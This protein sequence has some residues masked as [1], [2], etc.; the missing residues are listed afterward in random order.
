MAD[1]SG[2]EIAGY[3]IERLIAR[4]GMG[5]V[6]LARQSFPERK[7]ALKLL[8]HELASDPAF[9]ERFVR[10][11]NAAASLEHP[12]IVPVH[13]AGESDG[14]LYIAMRYVEGTDLH[15]LIEREGALPPERAVWICVQVAEALEEAHEHDLVH[16]DV[17]PGNILVAKG[18]RAYLT[19][20]GLIRRSALDTNLTKTGQFMGTIDYCA[21]EQI[22]GEEVDERA[23]VYSLGC[24]LYECL[25]GEPPFRRDTEVATLYAH[26][27][28]PMPDPGRQGHVVPPALAGALARATAKDVRDR[29]P[30]AARF[31]SELRASIGPSGVEEEAARR[32]TARTIRILVAA[33]SAV[34]LVLVAIRA[35]GWDTTDAGPPAGRDPS[36]GAVSSAHFLVEIDP[37]TGDVV[38][39]APFPPGGGDWLIDAFGGSV[40]MLGRDRIL[41]VDEESGSVENTFLTSD[42]GQSNTGY[43]RAFA[44]NYRTIWYDGRHAILRNDPASGDPLP[45]VDLR[46]VLFGFDFATGEGAVWAI[47]DP[48]LLFKID[49]ETGD[50]ASRMVLQNNPTDIAVGASGIWLLDAL[51]GTVTR[52]D[53]AT[54]DVVASVHVNGVLDDAV[55]NDEELWV[56]DRLGGTVTRVTIAGDVGPTVRVGPSTTDMTT[57]LGAIWLTDADGYLYRIDTLTDEVTRIDVSAPLESLTISENTQDI[58][59]VPGTGSAS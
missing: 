47:G 51:A 30:T 20:F 16:R 23:D 32:R 37:A 36:G 3:S 2:T 31:A 42:L 14:E 28:E 8:P 48:R 15:T 18:D 50:V 6:W 7:I 19:D 58:W 9:R 12:N 13:A 57:G 39:R 22:R 29:T 40:W 17:K 35:F 11:S 27:Q 44:V 54:G 5:E 21:P 4:G 34:G 45:Q 43:H 10:E 25:T 41:E 46:G 1:R 24:V 59:V 49:P 53:P 33:V 38:R 26:L 56:L 52:L 55:A